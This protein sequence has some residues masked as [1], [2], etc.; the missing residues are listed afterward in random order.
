MSQA[1]IGEIKREF[2]FYS[3]PF[4]I[5][6]SASMN[7]DL[8]ATEKRALVAKVVS[9]N[10]PK[11]DNKLNQSITSLLEPMGTVVAIH[12][13]TPMVVV[14][15]IKDPT[16]DCILVCLCWCCCNKHLTCCF[17]A[18]GWSYTNTAASREDDC[19]CIHSKTATM[20]LMMM[21]FTNTS[22]TVPC[23]LAALTIANPAA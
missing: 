18:V 4:P 15:V 17:P 3:I 16:M 6:G 5:T 10:L 21:P 13:V 23:T 2:D 9:G 19:I 20:G 12:T 22:S 11:E 14:V 1:N 7:R 8:F